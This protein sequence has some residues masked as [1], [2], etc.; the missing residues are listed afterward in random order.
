MTPDDP[1]HG[2]TA[3][4]HQGCRQACCNAARARYEKEGRVLR[5]QGMTR[6]VDATGA[7]RRIRA[8]MRIGWT[9]TDIAKVAGWPE[10]NYVLRILNGQKGKPTRQVSRATDQA[11][12]RAYDLLSMRTPPS[13]PA[14]ARTRAL[15]ERRGYPSPLA[16]DD[17]VID[18]PQARPVGMHDP[19]RGKRALDETL[20]LRRMA[21]DRTA[22]T[23]GAESVEV[24]RR[25]LAEGHS[26]R[27]ISTHTGL[28]TERYMD[29]VRAA[30]AAADQQ[31]DSHRQGVA[32]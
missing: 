26:Q 8:L 4:F 2:T 24:V 29:R 21:G 23:Y 27:W 22:R 12:R 28:K 5:S 13:S 32:A 20:I 11:I 9:S 7:Q 19:R 3:G 14:R 6:I 30:Q 15:A 18:D 31:P 16:W 25:L 17:D 10:R 1:R